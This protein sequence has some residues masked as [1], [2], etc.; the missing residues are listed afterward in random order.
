MVVPVNAV[1][2]KKP[3]KAKKKKIDQAAFHCTACAEGVDAKCPVCGGRR[4]RHFGD[5]FSVQC[6]DGECGRF[7]IPE[8][9]LE[10]ELAARKKNRQSFGL[11]VD[12]RRP[13]PGEEGPERIRSRARGQVQQQA[14]SWRVNC[15][16]CGGDISEPL[17][18]RTAKK[19]LNEHKKNQ[20]H[21][22]ILIREGLKC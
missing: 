6:I 19:F 11:S 21:D 7:Y 17:D 13:G 20:R 14:G 1:K 15:K 12:V 10:D 16:A 5:P 9:V 8:K 22:A 18:K 3:S 4:H 2:V